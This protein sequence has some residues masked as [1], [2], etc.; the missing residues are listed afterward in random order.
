MCN[1]KERKRDRRWY[2]FP[3]ST[4]GA[5]YFA[6][7]GGTGRFCFFFEAG[8]GGV[9]FF[10]GGTGRLFF[11]SEAGRGGFFFFFDGTGRGGVFFFFR[12]PGRDGCFWRWQIFWRDGAKSLHR[13]AKGGLNRPASRPWKALIFWSTKSKNGDRG[14]IVY[15]AASSVTPDTAPLLVVYIIYSSHLYLWKTGFR[16]KIR[17]LL[18][19]DVRTNLFSSLVVS[20]KSRHS[21]SSERQRDSYIVL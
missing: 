13:P 2:L 18:R 4:L 15:S 1:K 14:T 12:G 7:H 9:F 3:V 17:G 8:R 20:R 11:F 10:R 6:V 5:V 21:A 16:P 19:Y